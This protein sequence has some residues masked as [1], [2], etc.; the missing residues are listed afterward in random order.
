M[1][2]IFVFIALTLSFKAYADIESSLSSN[3]GVVQ[4]TAKILSQ[5]DLAGS[6][7]PI[8]RL[9]SLSSY[10]YVIEYGA[11]DGLGAKMC[12]VS[13]FELE[14]FGSWYKNL[15]KERRIQGGRPFGPSNSC[16]RLNEYNRVLVQR[17]QS[18]DQYAIVSNIG[19]IFNVTTLPKIMD[20]LQLLSG[21]S[22]SKSTVSDL[23]V[24]I[25]DYK[26]DKNSMYIRYGVS[27]NINFVQAYY[28]NRD[29]YT[30]HAVVDL[31]EQDSLREH[32]VVLA[33]CVKRY[34]S[35]L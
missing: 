25:R 4:N 11:L 10:S 31:K 21:M 18:G 17:L 5:L 14:D 23:S 30:C 22:W 20:S 3:I 7:G 35:D 1:R 33:E 9:T 13:G 19:D 32:S 15:F 34:T 2:K 26:K 28:G 27:I 29:K 12:K 6:A 16:Q 8:L 24:D